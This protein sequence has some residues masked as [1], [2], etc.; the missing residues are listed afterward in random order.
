VSD[1]QSTKVVSASPNTSHEQ[2][3]PPPIST[4]EP[5]SEK[6]SSA[7]LADAISSL[8]VTMSLQFRA[9]ITEDSLGAEPYRQMVSFYTR[10]EACYTQE[11]AK[12]LLRKKAVFFADEATRYIDETLRSCYRDACV[13][14]YGRARKAE[15][16]AVAEA[17]GEAEGVAQ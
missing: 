11:A 2:A 3:S 1:P 17:P 4:P 16:K 6:V 14:T 15:C 10:F 8:G 13:D 7:K 5:S 9:G 12:I